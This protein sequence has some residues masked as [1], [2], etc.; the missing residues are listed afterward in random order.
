MKYLPW[1]VLGIIAPA[2]GAQ[3]SVP[4]ERPPAV[5]P[6]RYTNSEG[7]EI[8]QNRG[9]AQGRGSSGQPA[10]PASRGGKGPAAKG[11]GRVDAR[12][13][14]VAVSRPPRAVVDNRER[15]NILTHELIA[16]TNDLETKRKLL[17][18]PRGTNDLVDQMYARLEREVRD[19]QEN[20]LALN[21]EIRRVA[22]E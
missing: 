15:I 5:Q 7:I 2:A 11:E 12:P 18:T 17:K 14:D 20:I 16:E 8:I 9:A 10:A 21:R 19:H 6:V 1:I 4:T 22:R 13:M 3:S